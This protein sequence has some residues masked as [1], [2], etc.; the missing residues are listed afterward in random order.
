MSSKALQTTIPSPRSTFFGT[1]IIAGQLPGIVTVAGAPAARQIVLHVQHTHRSVAV[2]YS[3]PD[4]TYR[5]DHIDPNRRYYVTAFDHTRR[6]NA[7]IRDNIT[8]KT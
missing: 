2:T 1:G 8:P 6:F 5:F 4:G 7:V 3:A